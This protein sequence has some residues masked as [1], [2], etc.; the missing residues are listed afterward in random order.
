MTQKIFGKA[1]EGIR[2]IAGLAGVG[3]G[4]FLANIIMNRLNRLIFREKEDMSRGVQLTDFSAHLDDVVVAAHY[5]APKSKLVHAIGRIV[6][7]A[8]V[9]PGL[10]VGNKTIN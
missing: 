4:V 7:A 3:I 8:L 9:I 5:I 2:A 6:P 1:S 10:E